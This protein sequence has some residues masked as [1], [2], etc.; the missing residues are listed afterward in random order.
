M[1]AKKTQ[2]VSSTS[3]VLAR[4]ISG[5]ISRI[6]S[7]PIFLNLDFPQPF[8]TQGK[9][10]KFRINIQKHLTKLLHGLLDLPFYWVPITSIF[11]STDIGFLFWI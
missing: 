11:P 4:E 5:L 3:F 10:L 1:V 9:M 6:T 2:V 7:F 8:N